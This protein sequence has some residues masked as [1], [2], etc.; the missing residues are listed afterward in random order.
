MEKHLD[1][2]EES[3]GEIQGSNQAFKKEEVV[4][5]SKYTPEEVTSSFEKLKEIMKNPSISSM[6]EHKEVLEGVL[7]QLN[8]PELRP[9][10]EKLSK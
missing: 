8:D 10:I 4:Q 9:Q 3:E 2:S 5:E 6:V 1:S 7:E